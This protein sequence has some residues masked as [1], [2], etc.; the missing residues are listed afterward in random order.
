MSITAT[1]CESYDSAGGLGELGVA[2]RTARKE[3]KRPSQIQ[4]AAP[5]R[6]ACRAPAVG[7]PGGGSVWRTATKPQTTPQEH[8]VEVP[9]GSLMQHRNDRRNTQPSR[10]HEDLRPTGPPFY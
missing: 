7:S 6:D 1:P 2:E 5:H 9:A 3:R 8:H 4:G 10:H